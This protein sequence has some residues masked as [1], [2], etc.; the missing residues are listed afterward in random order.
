MVRYTTGRA[1][2]GRVMCSSAPVIASRNFSSPCRA[3]NRCGCS[4]SSASVSMNS[5]R[6]S[7]T[8][9]TGSAAACSTCSGM[10]RFTYTLV[11]NDSAPVPSA[12]G[13]ARSTVVTGALPAKTAPAEPSTVTRW[14][15]CSVVVAMPVPTTHG[16]PSSRATIAAWQVM[17]PPSV[18]TAAARRMAGTQSGLVIR[19]TSTSPSR[20][21]APSSGEPSTRTSPDAE[22]GE[23]LNPLTRGSSPGAPLLP[24]VVTGR[25]WTSQ[26]ASSAIA[27]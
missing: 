10:A 4:A 2:N 22:P 19:A 15:S 18:T 8:P 14:P 24:R 17:P 26:V 3:R 1:P 9:S 5:A 20:S 12:S 21:R 25:D 27:H 13:T 11:P 16:T 23:A 6:S 7:P